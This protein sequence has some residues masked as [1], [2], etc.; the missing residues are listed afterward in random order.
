MFAQFSIRDL[1]NLNFFILSTSLQ[2]ETSILKSILR[3][4]LYKVPINRRQADVPNPTSDMQEAW[5]EN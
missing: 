1:P 3:R 5:H 4:N 2:N